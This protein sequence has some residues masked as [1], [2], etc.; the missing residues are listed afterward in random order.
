[1]EQNAP[2]KLR[3]KNSLHCTEPEDSL[4][5]SHKLFTCLYAETD[6]SSTCHHISFRYILIL[7]SQLHL[8]LSS[9]LFLSGLLT[10]ILYAF[11]GP[12]HVLHAPSISSSLIFI[13]LIDFGKEYI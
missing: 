5:C 13:T 12:L 11:Y 4:P 2:E 1:M 6:E 9:G 10:K 8:G 3:Q 7:S